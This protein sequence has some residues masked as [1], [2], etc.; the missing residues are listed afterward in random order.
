MS[1]EHAL[2]IV[3]LAAGEASRYGGA[4]Q[5]LPV[6]G[7]PMVRG[8][9]RAALAVTDRVVVVTGAHR[10][11]VEPAL[12]GL[13]AAP[14]FHAGWAEGMGG[15]IAFG[16]RH[17]RRIHPELDAIAICLAD[18]PAI[19]A[20]HLRALA[21]ASRAAPARIVASDHGDGI[22]GAPC[23]FPARFFGALEALRGPEGARRLLRL[24]AADVQAVPMPDARIDIDTPDDYRSWQVAGSA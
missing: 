17:L 16:V 20:P 4:K 5:L 7:E 12:A 15:S 13:A 10:E 2:G 9:A 19:R 14:V 23:V 8:A 21:A 24:H 22:Q 1:R 11:D 18:Q 3:L 6:D